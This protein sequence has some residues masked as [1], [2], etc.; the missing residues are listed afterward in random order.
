MLCCNCYSRWIARYEQRKG[1]MGP[2]SRKPHIMQA[3]GSVGKQRKVGI[4][5]LKGN[6]TFLAAKWPECNLLIIMPSLQ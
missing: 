5:T 3:V 6:H 4:S 2:D 1:G